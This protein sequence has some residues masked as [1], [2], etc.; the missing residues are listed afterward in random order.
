MTTTHTH[1]LPARDHDAELLVRAR[2]GDLSA[3]EDLYRAHHGAILAVARRQVGT[4]L[5]EDVVAEAFTRTFALL[6]AGRGPEVAFRAYVISAVKN[7]YA[8]VVRKDH[9]VVVTDQED[10]LDTAAPSN[11]IDAL[12]DR[13]LIRSAFDALPARDRTV[14]WWTAVEGRSAEDL[15]AVWRTTGPAVRQHAFRAREALRIA[16]LDAHVATPAPESCRLV[17]PVFS[18]QARGRVDARSP[19][20]RR[21]LT[22]LDHCRSC[23]AAAAEVA[24][25]ARALVRRTAG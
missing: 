24:E 6:T 20:G 3:L 14:L 4:E 17:R 2:A 7:V 13:D 9:R 19:R 25:A 11:P 8:G 23:A 10:A 15:A 12:G 16:Y 5:A 18:R 21:A 1:A 22:H